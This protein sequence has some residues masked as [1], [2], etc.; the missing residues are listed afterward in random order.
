M[1]NLRPIRRG[2]A[3]SRFLAGKT[4]RRGQSVVEFALVLP[5]L[6]ILGAV[7]IDLGR[8]AFAR[9]TLENA[10]R[11][12]AF[13]ASKTPTSFNNALP[14]PA[15]AATNLV[16]C[17]TQLETRG[18]PISI[19]PGDISLVCDPVDCTPGIGHAVTVSVTGRFSLVTPILSVFFGGTSLALASSA[20]AQI[21][22]LPPA[23]AGLPWATP[24]PTPSPSGS[25]SASPSPTVDPGCTV[26]SAG[27][28]F[29]TTPNSG[30]APLTMFVT[31]TSTF[32][33]CPIDSWEWD[34]GDGL[35]SYGQNPTAHTY[36][37]SG[38]YAMT[39]TVTNVAGRNTTGAV[40]IRV[41]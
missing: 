24:A 5:V 15:G 20:T 35:R 11:E 19:A 36:G 10:A 6:I 41:K 13:Q 30:H 27:F 2:S 18:S 25:A 26:P 38:N 40:N 16:V 1:L 12:G 4:A 32:G 37:S 28:T 33:T 9:V 23:P 7:T 17:R 22:T 31:D 8:I 21:E 34:W 14:C 39:L 3:T 29:V